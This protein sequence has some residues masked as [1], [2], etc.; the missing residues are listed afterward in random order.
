M[1]DGQRQFLLFN[2]R[3]QRL[4]GRLFFADQIEQI[5]GDL[6][7]HAERS[8]IGRQLVD[9]AFTGAAIE[10]PKPAT[11]GGQLRS[12]GI[13]NVEILRLGELEVSFL[14]DLMQLAL[15]EPVGRLPDQPTRQRVVER[16]GKVKGMR[17]KVIAQQ[18]ARL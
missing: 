18:D 3:A 14:D 16:A 1:D 17:E 7:R 10:C 6:K 11:A 2:V 12:L 8:A 13:D 4:A 9:Y 5:V 15:A